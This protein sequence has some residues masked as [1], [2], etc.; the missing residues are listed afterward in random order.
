MTDNNYNHDDGFLTWEET[1]EADATAPE[2]KVLPKG[3]YPFVVE[4]V[5][6][7]YVSDQKKN[8]GSVSKYAGCPMANVTFRITGKAEDGE[9]LE[10]TRREN[11]ILHKKF[12]WKISQLFISVGL[13]KQGE[14]LRM[15]WPALITR[16]GQCEVSVNEY[17]KRDGSKGQSNQIDRF[18]DP[19]ATAPAWKRGF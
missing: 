3:T 18:C 8:D 6:R 7:T 10:I 9:E 17:T 15:N 4:D 2:W 12:Q 14:Q 13:A 5:E 19:S 1:F 16:G 11:F